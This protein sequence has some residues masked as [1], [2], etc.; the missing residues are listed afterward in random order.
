M[1]AAERAAEAWQRF[2]IRRI[3]D[4]ENAVLGAELEAIQMAGPPLRGSLAF[5]AE[6]GIVWSSGR[7]EGNVLL[8]R[9]R[10]D[11]TVTLGILLRA[12]GAARDAAGAR[13]HGLDVL[14]GRRTAG[15]SHRR[16]ALSRSH[17]DAGTSATDGGGC[18]RFCGRHGC[19]ATRQTGPLAT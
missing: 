5:A 10:P 16:N 7:L 8:R 17:D 13:R 18:G 14:P 15:L 19:Q 11:N 9:T 4:L 2:D 6:G 1:P 12:R 3:E